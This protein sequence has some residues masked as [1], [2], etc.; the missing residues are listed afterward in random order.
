[1]SKF[2]CLLILMTILIVGCKS[3]TVVIDTACA[4]TKPITTTA[5]ERKVM[6]RQTKEEIA[7][8]NDMWDYKCGKR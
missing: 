5:A 4:W 1:M 8:H 2:K 6:T 7:T 3:T